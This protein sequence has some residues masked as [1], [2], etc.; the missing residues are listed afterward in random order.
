MGYFGY[1]LISAVF[2]VVF[3]AVSWVVTGL[4]HLSGSTEMIVRMLL[5]GLV[6]A[7]FG[8]I[9]WHRSRRQSQPATDADRAQDDVAS[10]ER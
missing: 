9:Y 7:G 2:M 5:M 3:L 4:L 6:L 8:A 1:Y 10:S